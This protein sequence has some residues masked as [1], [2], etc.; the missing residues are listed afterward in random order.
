MNCSIE[1]GRAA[2]DFHCDVRA[3]AAGL[4]E[5]GLP[6]IVRLRVDRTGRAQFGRKFQ[7]FIF[8][9]DG[10]DFAAAR[11]AQGLT[12]QQANHT[13]SHDNG[14]D[15]GCNLYTINCVQC[16]GNWLQQRGLII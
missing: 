6:W 11:N 8:D 12:H 3:L 2:D 13:G 7:F 4:R 16:N 9:I 10:N 14:P 15:V 1:G 5:N